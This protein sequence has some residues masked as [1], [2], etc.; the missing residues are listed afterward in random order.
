MFVRLNFIRLN[1]ISYNFIY[2]YW[3]Q[4]PIILFYPIDHVQPATRNFFCS[5]GCFKAAV[6]HWLKLVLSP[7]WHPWY[8]PVANLAQTSSMRIPQTKTLPCMSHEVQYP[9]ARPVHPGPTSKPQDLFVT[10]LIVV[11]SSPV[12]HASPT[13]VLAL[14]H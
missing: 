11:L 13:C 5:S 12:A 4:S 6:S 7:R 1:I 9:N 10:L 2:R 8:H 14:R 3:T